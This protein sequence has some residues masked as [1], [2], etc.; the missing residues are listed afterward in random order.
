M[1]TN[2][3]NDRDIFYLNTEYIMLSFSLYFVL[4]LPLLYLF[5]NFTLY[6]PV[7]FYLFSFFPVLSHF[8]LP[9]PP[10]DGGVQY[11]ILAGT[12]PNTVVPL[13]KQN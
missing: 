10:H 1:F 7:I 13:P 4:S 12:V 6:L 8:H 5:Y 3:K 11:F 9:P 2:K